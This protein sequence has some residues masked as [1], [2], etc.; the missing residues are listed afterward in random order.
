MSDE[1]VDHPKS[2]EKEQPKKSR[3]LPSEKAGEPIAGKEETVVDGDAE[4]SVAAESSKTETTTPT[5]SSESSVRAENAADTAKTSDKAE[6]PPASTES[7]K[8]SKAGRM[9]FRRFAHRR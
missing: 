2:D 4:G 5:E 9:R 3:R 1:N 7:S 8:T 6:S